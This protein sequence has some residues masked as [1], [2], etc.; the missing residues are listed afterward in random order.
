MSR[1]VIQIEDVLFFSMSRSLQW[2]IRIEA[3]G[4]GTDSANGRRLPVNDGSFP[5]RIP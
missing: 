5:S 4:G 1:S 2:N 3:P